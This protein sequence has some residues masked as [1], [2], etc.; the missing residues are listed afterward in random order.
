MG[1][2]FLRIKVSWAERD[3]GLLVLLRK[4]EKMGCSFSG[5][6]A[7][8]DAVSRGRDVGIN[9]NRFRIVR[10]LGEGGFVYVFLVKEVV[11]DPSCS[12]SKIKIKT[13]KKILKNHPHVSDD[14]T[15]VMKR[16]LIQNSEQLE[17]V[18]EE[19]R[20]SSLFSHPNLLPFPDH[21]IIAVKT[22]Q[23]DAWNHETYLL[24]HVH[25]SPSYPFV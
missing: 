3:C 20:V 10:R 16:V 12:A 5:L 4:K 8:C 2:P 22:P 6:N 23:E 21:E 11:T 19:I 18:R 15:Y 7:L 1:I 24:F 9:G 25:S 17:L 13:I 14:G